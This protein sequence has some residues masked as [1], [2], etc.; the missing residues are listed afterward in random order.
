MPRALFRHLVALGLGLGF[1]L[2]A[3]DVGEAAGPPGA[4]KGLWSCRTVDPQTGDVRIDPVCF[5][6]QLVD[7]YRRLDKYEDVAEVLQVRQGIGE[8]PRRVETRIGCAIVDGRLHVRT[9][10][11]GPWRA[12]RGLR[13]SRALDQA[14]LRY[15]LWLAPH[16]ALKYAE[17]PAKK[18]RDGVREGFTATEA[19]AVTI[20]SRPMVHLE[21]TSGD[22]TSADCTAKFDLYV[23]PESML[24]ERITGQQRMPDGASYETMLTITP[25]RAE[26]GPEL[27]TE[28]AAVEDPVIEP[29]PTEPTTPAPASPPGPP[30]GRPGVG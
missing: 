29:V 25:T 4:P 24:V 26:D 30:V 22:G 14:A 10:S 6:D 16:M 18:F 1:A 8:R 23:N 21:L 27:P 17:E 13:R 12:S 11:P 20:D 7:R 9:P 19:E 3:V 15:D 2:A 5:F 28:P